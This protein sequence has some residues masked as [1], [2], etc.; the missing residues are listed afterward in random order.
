[1]DNEPKPEP[2][3]QKHA[4]GH[5]T[6]DA[7]A[8]KETNKKL[9][10]ETLTDELTGLYN[11]RGFEKQIKQ[12]FA[13]AKR[14]GHGLT[15][16]FFDLDNF[17][18]VNEISHETGD[19]MLKETAQTLRSRLRP[20]DV[21]ARWGGDEFVAILPQKGK[22]PDEDAEAIIQRLNAAVSEQPFQGGIKQT[23]SI[24]VARYPNGD[25]KTGE[26]LVRRAD[27]ALLEAKSGGKNAFKVWDATTQRRSIK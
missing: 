12:L 8:L 7:A 10:E 19:T 14:L 3:W 11:R 5:K 13:E 1:M 25:L 24:G 9:Q 23:I 2:R 6:F 26:E 17:K 21:L 4:K 27:D 16:L 20:S 15:V 18:E 22:L